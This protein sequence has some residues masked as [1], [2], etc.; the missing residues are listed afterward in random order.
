MR[1][2]LY[3]S[4]GVAVST[5]YE[6]NQVYQYENGVLG[7]SIAPAPGMRMTRHA[8]PEYHARVQ[9]MLRILIPEYPWEILNPFIGKTKRECVHEAQTALNIRGKSA[10]ARFLFEQTQSCWY[11]WSNHGRI[12]PKTPGKACGLC[13]PC[14]VRRT[15]LRDQAAA[16]CF[17]VLA[18]ASRQRRADRNRAAHF[19]DWFGFL[20]QV[21]ACRDEFEFYSLLNPYDRPLVGG[22]FGL[23]LRELHGLYARFAEEF[24]ETFQIGG[25]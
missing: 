8:H 7:N 6:A 1:S 9:E 5:T 17:D 20:E 23:G 12:G 2:L 10:S 11:H 21:Q 13:I 25:L 22:K 18:L 4:V 14:L 16:Y 24:F 19:F 15:A 3:L